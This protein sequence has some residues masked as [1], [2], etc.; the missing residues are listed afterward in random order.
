MKNP[1]KK[2]VQKAWAAVGSRGEFWLGTICPDRF[3]LQSKLNDLDPEG[4]GRV[5]EIEIHFH[6]PARKK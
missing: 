4:V 2:R 6:L 3:Y 5:V 1:S